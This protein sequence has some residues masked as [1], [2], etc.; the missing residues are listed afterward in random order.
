MDN[1]AEGHVSELNRFSTKLITESREVIIY[2][3]NLVLGLG[4]AILL[5]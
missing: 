1:Y 2:P 5:N 4:T 3:N